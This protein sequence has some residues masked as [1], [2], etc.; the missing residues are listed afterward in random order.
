M[1]IRDGKASE[2]LIGGNLTLIMETMGTPYEIDP[3]GK[4]LFLEDLS[5][6]P[7][8][9]DAYFTQLRQAGKP[10]PPPGSSSVTA[11]RAN[12]AAPS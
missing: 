2:Q 4:L 7:H 1:V 3:A 6:Q 8:Q 12:R 9:Y 11:R 5:E 10:T